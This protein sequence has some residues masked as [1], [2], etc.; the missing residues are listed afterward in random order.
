MPRFQVSEDGGPDHIYYNI[1]IYNR[2]TVDDPILN[3]SPTASFSETRSQALIADASKYEFSIVRFS[4]NGGEI[5]LWIPTI[6]KGQTDENRTIYHMSMYVQMNDGKTNTVYTV[7]QTRNVV[8]ETQN[9]QE[10]VQSPIKK[11]DLSTRY[12]HVNI[13]SHFVKM[14]NYNFN[15]LNSAVGIRSNTE[16]KS[17]VLNFPQAPFLK[18]HPSTN[19]L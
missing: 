2:E 7:K 17:S 6:Q 1:N 8:F 10:T 15:A 11:Q 19:L 14:I 9:P 18:Y 4:I 3:P 13:Y 12:Y 5:P 16:Y